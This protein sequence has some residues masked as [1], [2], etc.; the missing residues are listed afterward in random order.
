MTIRLYAG[1]EEREALGFQV[2]THSV[3]Q[4]TSELVSITPLAEFGLPRGTNAFT[5]SRFLVPWLCHFE[6]MGIFADAS[7]MLLL[8][9]LSELA[10]LYDPR[11]AVQVVKHPN[12]KTRHKIKYRG[13]ALETINVDYDRKNWA[14]LMLVNAGHPVWAGIAPNTLAGMK[15]IDLLQFKHIPDDLIGQL[16]GEWNRLVDEGQPVEG[17]KLCHWSSGIPGF[18]EYHQAPGAELWHAVRRRAMG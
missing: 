9:D 17:A 14:S 15:L 18:S 2:F 6:G 10:A 4:N 11:Y 16:P 13:T 5:F 7:D 3:I 8:G 12:Y 1:Y